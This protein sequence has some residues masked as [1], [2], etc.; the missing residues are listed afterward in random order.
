METSRFQGLESL[1]E[2]AS[3]SF[4]KRPKNGWGMIKEDIRFV[5]AHVAE[6]EHSSYAFWALGR[7]TARTYSQTLWSLVKSQR[8]WWG[9]GFL[10]G[11][12]PIEPVLELQ[13]TLVLTLFPG[14]KSPLQCPHRVLVS[15]YGRRRVISKQ[16]LDSNITLLKGY[17]TFSSDPLIYMH[18]YALACSCSQEPCPVTWDRCA[19]IWAWW[20]PYS[21]SC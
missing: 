5:C 11:N 12:Q 6:E 16:P 18:G 19:L 21:H 13:Y 17:W 15:I 10:V 1:A 20:M 2:T 3:F 9:A 4:S 8:S 14:E 7:F